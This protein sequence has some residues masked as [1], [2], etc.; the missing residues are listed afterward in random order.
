MHEQTGDPFLSGVVKNLTGAHKEILYFLS[1]RLCSTT[2]LAAIRGQSDRNI[3][4]VRDTYTRNLQRQLYQHLCK[5][6]ENESL[7]LRE[8]E[9]L[10]LYEAALADTSRL[11]A[12]VK[13]ENKYP[14]RKKAAYAEKSMNGQNGG[15]L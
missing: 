9:F 15:A 5:K 4:K 10:A 13:R 12:K 11:S 1:L 2:R 6:K 7:S 8:K 14:K 3:R